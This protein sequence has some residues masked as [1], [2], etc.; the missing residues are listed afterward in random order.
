MADAKGRSYLLMGIHHLPG[1]AVVARVRFFPVVGEPVDEDVPVPPLL[2]RFP[3]ETILSAMAE[4]LDAR[5]RALG[6]QP[7]VS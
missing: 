6:T 3:Q 5:S 2:V 1:R 7:V 4:T